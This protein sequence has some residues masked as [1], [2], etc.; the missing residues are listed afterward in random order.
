MGVAVAEALN[1]ID[2]ARPLV[3]NDGKT[4][5]RSDVV[6]IGGGPSGLRA[7]GRLAARGLSVRVLEKKARVGANI[8]CTGIVGREL[9]DEFDLDRGSVIG[10]IRTVRLVSPFATAL[11]YEHPRPFAC[12]VDREK[13][14]GGLAA[15]AAAAG[16]EIELGVSV[17]GLEVR[18]EGVVVSARG[19]GGE[20]VRRAAA[21]AVLATGVESSLPQRAGLGRAR[22]FLNGAQVEAVLDVPDTTTIFFGR[23]LAPGGFGWA[24][25]SG[26]GRVRIG[27]LTKTEPKA[28]LRK[29]I[30][31]NFG[32]LPT[33]AREAPIRTKPV[34]QGLL[35]PTA[36]DR[37]L[38]VGEAAGQ[39]K[40]TTG[41]GISYGLVCADL[42]A[43]VIL[44]GFR[45]SSFGPSALAEYERR[46]RKALEREIVVGYTTRKICA[47]LSDRQI[48]GLFQLART[49]GIVPI[50]RERADFEWHSG[51][52]FALLQRLSF[53]RMFR[54]ARDRFAPGSWDLS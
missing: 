19:E 49:D 40:T 46:W 38:S 9:F 13:F 20:P 14:D 47:R 11:A 41:G 26:E 27:L 18:P 32:A 22:D 29:M 44:D 43:D 16:A 25:P 17:E 35:S 52:I 39:T 28:A 33:S 2:S 24:V 36:G 10:E 37:V 3:E 54:D 4:M 30:E 48:E 7:A 51:L 5:K 50:I 12:V 42:A 53:M 8:L 23:G 1:E 21:V 31:A 45:T 34:A 15:A 6:V